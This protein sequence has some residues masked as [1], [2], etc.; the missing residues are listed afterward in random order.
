MSVDLSGLSGTLTS[1]RTLV[2]SLDLAN[3]TNVTCVTTAGAHVPTLT[4]PVTTGASIVFGNQLNYL[5]LQ[6]LCTSGTALTCYVIG[7]TYSE[8]SSISASP[9][10]GS[11]WIPTLLTKF[12]ATTATTGAFGVAGD[13][14]YAGQTYAKSLGD[15]KIYNGET[16]TCP[17]GF[18]IVDVTGNELIELHM[19]AGSAVKSNAV[20]GSI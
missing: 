8:A 13:L 14:L 19:V 10:T 17:G 11:V 7:W 12:V 1:T 16:T 6:T 20:I 18:V 2:S 5:K 4:R 15:A 3:L 9:S